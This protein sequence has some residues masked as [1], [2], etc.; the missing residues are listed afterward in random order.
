MELSGQLCRALLAVQGR[1]RPTLEDMHLADRL[2][3]HVLAERNRSRQRKP[4]PDRQPAPHD[5]QVRVSRL[6]EAVSGT[7]EGATRGASRPAVE[8]TRAALFARGGAI[9]RGPARTEPADFPAHSRARAHAGGDSSAPAV[10][11]RAGRSAQLPVVPTAARA[12]GG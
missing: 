10:R 9:C 2:A 4:R 7:R 5:L 8:K 12:W 1:H 3:E 11:N 6:K